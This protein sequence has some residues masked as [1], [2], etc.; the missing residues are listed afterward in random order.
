MSGK[1][2]AAVLDR[3][4]DEKTAH[5]M[6]V[7]GSI[8]VI[9]ALIHD[10]DHIRQA[11]NGGYTI[12]LS[13]WAL[14][15]TV[16]IFPGV[17]IFLARS[18]RMSAAAG[19]PADGAYALRRAVRRL[20]LRHILRQRSQGCAAD[21]GLLAGYGAADAAFCLAGRTAA[22]RLYKHLRKLGAVLITSMG[23]KKPIGGL[24]LLRG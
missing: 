21:A 6:F 4:L 12:P 22:A 20:A 9:A 18:R 1:Q 8:M 17:T 13:L 11:L 14:N 10:G 19:R 2:T 24:L 15:L 23:L 5:P 16:Y 7:C 3:K